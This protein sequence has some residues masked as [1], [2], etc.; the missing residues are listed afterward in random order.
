MGGGNGG[1]GLPAVVV[2]AVNV[3][4]L[5]PLDTQYTDTGERGE[6]FVSQKDS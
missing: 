2:I 6:P 1:R 3:K 4:D 5:L